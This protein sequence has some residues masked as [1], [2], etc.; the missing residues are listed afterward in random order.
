MLIIK[1]LIGGSPCSF[2]SIS[3]T[4]GRETKAE[5]Q[6]WELFKNY[7]IAKEKFEPDYFLYENNWSASKAIKDQIQEELGCPL[8]RINSNLVSAQTRDRFYV[9]NWEVEQPED[10]G[11]LLKDILETGEPYLDKSQCLTSSYC[12]QSPS[13]AGIAFS[14]RKKQRTLIAEPVRVGTLPRKDGSI[15][16]S[17]QYRIYN[18]E[19]KSTTLCGE[20]GGLVAKTGLYA[21][22]HNGGVRKL[23]TFS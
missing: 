3:R 10:R 13:P 11:I 20:G 5:G 18:T 14:L 9:F 22:K 16:N 15:S 4:A 17:K 21:V 12:K 6:G 8:M 7:L 2:W 23:R 19:G 1:L